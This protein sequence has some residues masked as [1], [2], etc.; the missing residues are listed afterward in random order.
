[1]IS[2][3]VPTTGLRITLAA[4]LASIELHA[5]DELLVVGPH[6]GPD[7]RVR[8]VS[9]PSA[10]DWGATE[11]T[12]GIAQ[13]RGAYLAFMDDDD[14]YVPDHRALMQHAIET[15]PD[16]PVVFRMQYPDESFLWTRP[17]VAIGNVSTQML[18]LPNDPTKL[19][20]WLSGRRECDFD[21]LNSSKWDHADLVWSTDVICHRSEEKY[22]A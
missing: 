6:P 1:L 9:C 3:I 20:S 14:V 21:F 5:Q 15:Y 17:V 18:L 19:G 2:F 8:H 7:S 22:E 13:A 12:L 10:H 16:R 11:R 4:T